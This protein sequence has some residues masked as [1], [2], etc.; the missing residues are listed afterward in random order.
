MLNMNSIGDRL[1]ELRGNRSQLDFAKEI[2]ISLR[3]YKY[4]ESGERLL[5]IDVLT[6][7]S[8]ISGK[9]TDWI[10]AGREH[11]VRQNEIIMN[12]PIKCC[13]FCGGHEVHICRTNK[14]SCWIRCEECG[15]E[16]G[17]HKK[18]SGAIQNWNRRHYDDI[19]AKIVSDDDMED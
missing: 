6:R 19:P 9:S 7:I 1:Y 18:R 14:N 4:Y 13:P 16:A 8:E 15:A 12:D 11:A 10:L 2:G 3:A 17:S 5:P